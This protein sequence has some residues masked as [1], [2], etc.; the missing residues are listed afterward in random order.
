MLNEQLKAQESLFKANCKRQLANLKAQLKEAEGGASGGADDAE[1]AK[2]R[3]IE[4]MHV[5]V[6]HVHTAHT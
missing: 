3:E 5:K 4:D 2:I 6:A 1:A